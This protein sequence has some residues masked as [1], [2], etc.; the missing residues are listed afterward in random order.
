[1]KCEHGYRDGADVDCPK[2]ATARERV[3]KK[4][5]ERREKRDQFAAAAVTLMR[6]NRI[7][8]SPKEFASAIAAYSF[9]IA[10]EMLKASEE[11]AEADAKAMGIDNL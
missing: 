2:C 7:D 4:W 8:A 1:M 3:L 10:D 9:N 6:A 5:R 11:R